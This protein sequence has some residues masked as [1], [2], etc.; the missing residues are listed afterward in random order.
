M[1]VFSI[2]GFAF[3]VADAALVAA[4]ETP[5]SGSAAAASDDPRRSAGYPR[6]AKIFDGKTFEGWEADRST[7][8]IVDGGAM[9][10]FGGTSRLAYTRLRTTTELWCNLEKETVRAAVDGVEIVRYTHPHPEE[11]T[12]PEKR[13]IPGPIGMFRHGA[14]GSEYKEIYL[15]PDP[16]DDKLLTVNCK[17]ISARGGARYP[18]AAFGRRSRIT[19]LSRDRR[20]RRGRR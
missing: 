3:W 19:R 20:A 6:C 10:G 12:D 16:K 15:E 18:F 9:R 5:F 14:G 7:W 1:A 2:C 4:D 17:R 13:I 8:S 11:R